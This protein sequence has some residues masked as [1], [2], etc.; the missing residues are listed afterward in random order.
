MR[1]YHNCLLLDPVPCRTWPAPQ[2][3]TVSFV[4]R[5]Y[6]RMSW[7]CCNVRLVPSLVVLDQVEVRGCWGSFATSILCVQYL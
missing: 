2:Y 6:N 4:L 5:C 7:K 3:F 1:V